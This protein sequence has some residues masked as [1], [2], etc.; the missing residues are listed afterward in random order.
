[1]RLWGFE[2]PFS[3]PFCDESP[4][5][6][7]VLFVLS[8]SALTLFSGCRPGPR[9][10]AVQAIRAL[11][12]GDADA[13]A[14]LCTPASGAVVRLFDALAR[15][16]GAVAWRLPVPAAGE[17]RVERVEHSEVPAI[18]G[19]AG[20]SV[21]RALVT[22]ADAQGRRIRVPLVLRHG[23]WRIDLFRLASSVRLDRVDASAPSSPPSPTP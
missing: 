11:E 18:V 10:V 20:E 23:H 2:S 5:L 8:A 9:A 17:V 13:F 4:M 12:H 6:S 1:M 14:G 19:A 3:H 16:Q 22:L 21:D 15:T 7:R